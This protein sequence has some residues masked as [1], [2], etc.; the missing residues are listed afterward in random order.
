[1]S[2]LYKAVR[3]LGEENIVLKHQRRMRERALEQT[4]T[5]SFD[6]RHREREAHHLLRKRTLDFPQISSPTHPRPFRTPMGDTPRRTPTFSRVHSALRPNRKPKVMLLREGKDRFEA[7]RKIQADSKNFK[8]WVALFWSVTTF[9]VLWCIG[10]VAFW[11]T[12]QDTLHMTYFQ[13]LYFCYISLLTIGYGDLAPKS[14][15]GRVFFVIWSL[16]AVPTMTILVSDLGNTVVSK[17]KKWSDELADFTVLPKK[18]LWRSLFNRYP[19]LYNW[20]ERRVESYA[21]KKRL[22]RGFDTAD[23]RANSPMEPIGPTDRDLED[24]DSS[25][26]VDEVARHPTITSLAA[27][28]E[29][30]SSQKPTRASLSRQLALSIQKVSGDFRLP[31]KRYTYEEWVEFTRLIRLTTPERLDRTLGEL[32]DDDDKDEGL[33]H[34][35]WI[36]ENSPMVSGIPESEWL[37][38][39]LCESLVRLEKRKEIARDRANVAALGSLETRDPLQL[40]TQ[41]GTG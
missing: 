7:M 3:E 2:S 34:W 26:P 17:F 25:T 14:N 38:E 21:L 19:W 1:M 41:A 22:K 28:A 40:P 6:L 32:L 23:P 37:L 36:G 35:D 31:V 5:N 11:R 12:E 30:D 20:L 27:E 16:I 29:R 24:P 33:V 18:G 15:A 8:R 10:A 4:V 13:A 9:L 39:R